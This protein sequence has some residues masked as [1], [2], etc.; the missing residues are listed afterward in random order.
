LYIKQL[1]LMQPL[2]ISKYVMVL[3]GVVQWAYHWKHDFLVHHSSVRFMGRCWSKVSTETQFWQ[4]ITSAL[5]YTVCGGQPYRQ[6]HKCQV[7]QHQY[8]L[9]KSLSRSQ[10]S[11]YELDLQSSPREWKHTCI[12]AHTCTG[13]LLRTSHGT[14]WLEKALI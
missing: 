4:D 1:T 5:I 6:R 13:M 14:K 10:C 7:S 2:K 11:S 9:L 8:L 3:G 12:C